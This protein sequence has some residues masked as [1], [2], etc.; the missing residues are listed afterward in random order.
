MRK[1]LTVVTP[2]GYYEPQQATTQGSG[3]YVPRI[4]YDDARDDEAM[5]GEIMMDDD[6]RHSHPIVYCT[7]SADSDSISEFSS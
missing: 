2:K 6:G 7:T 5:C 1:T 4:H 3:N